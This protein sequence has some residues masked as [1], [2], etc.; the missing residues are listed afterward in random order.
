[1]KQIILSG[2]IGNQMFE[3]AF[4]LSCKK[5]G[6][7]VKLNRDLYEINRMH[8]GYMLGRAFGIPDEQLT[9]CCSVSV[10]A[11][12]V[13]RRFKPSCFIYHEQPFSYDE[14]VY[15]TRCPY[16]DGVFINPLYLHTVEADLL[17]AF[18][19]RHIDADNSSIAEQMHA[20]NSVSLH[21]RRGDY[22][23]VPQYAVCKEDYYIRAVGYIKSQVRNPHF[24]LFSDDIEWSEHFIQSFGV[25]Y[26]VVRHNRNVNS[27]RDMYLMSQCKHN[28]IANS[29]FSWWGGWLNT[30]PSKIVVCP[31]EWTKNN[32]FTPYLDNWIKI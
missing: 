32:T 7:K 27:Y 16:I 30:D 1:M 4:Y 22:L 12:R 24:F 10:L 13:L 17:E 2:G 3:Y 18:Q 5:R 20:C 19:F 8:N 26:T 21:V 11:T 25:D 9:K 6:L 15:T 23:N 29:T 31:T 28:I 14:S